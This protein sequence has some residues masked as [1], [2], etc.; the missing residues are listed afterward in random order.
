MEGRSRELQLLHTTAEIFVP[1]LFVRTRSRNESETLE[2]MQFRA[3]LMTWIG[4][5]SLTVENRI[6]SVRW[7]AGARPHRGET[8]IRREK[9]G[10]VLGAAGAG[11]RESGRSETG[12][13][14]SRPSARSSAHRRGRSPRRLSRWILALPHTTTQSRSVGKTLHRVSADYNT[15]KN[16]EIRRI[17][18]ELSA[19]CLTRDPDFHIL[20]L[21][22]EEC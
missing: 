15:L 10:S 3:G 12:R 21:A 16:I 20:A 18:V 8:M 7:F 11:A 17:S 22:C 5:L 1:A 4:I 14:A 2:E 6:E 9:T 19:F 13:P